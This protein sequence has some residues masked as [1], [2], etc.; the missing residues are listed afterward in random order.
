M[1]ETPQ[2][3]APAP[4][5]AVAPPAKPDYLMAWLPHLLMVLTGWIGPLIIWLVKKDDDKMAAFH[6]KQA[7]FWS[8]ALFVI[9]VACWI[10]TV[11]L[12]AIAGPL[13]FVGMCA[14][15]L[16]ILGNLVYGIVAIVKSSKGE[17][18]KYFFVADKFCAAEFAAAYPDAAQAAPAAE[19]QPPA[20]G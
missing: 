6:G 7:L 10:L 3:P 13:G 5:P 11:I 9:V 1:T 8:I 16:A 20:E 19:Q 14:M 2:Q 17:P 12:L 15:W 18:F 4:Q